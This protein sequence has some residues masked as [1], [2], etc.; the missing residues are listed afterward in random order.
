MP[1][2]PPRFLA[3]TVK[4]LLPPPARETILG[5]L[6]E[7]YTSPSAYAADAAS[8]IAAA[9]LSQL[10]RSVSL[11]GVVLEA[12]VVYAAFVASALIQGGPLILA[13]IARVTT[14]VMAALL[15]RAVYGSPLSASKKDPLVAWWKRS[16]MNGS[17]AGQR[18]CNVLQLLSRVYLPIYFGCGATW[19]WQLMFRNSRAFPAILTSLDGVFI[20]SLAVALLRLASGRARGD[21]PRHAA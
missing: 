16:R 20:A 15:W 17:V 19:C 1:M 7:R 8:A 2:N 18:L 21:R 5:D 13:S 3:A 11:S 12:S 4:Y 14:I 9:V 10:R 6:H